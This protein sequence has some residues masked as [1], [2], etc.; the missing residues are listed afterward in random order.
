[1]EERFTGND[2]A[3][4]SAAALASRSVQR[5]TEAGSDGSLVDPAFQRAIVAAA[6]RA[7]SGDNC[8][9]WHFRFRRNAVE[10][11]L[12]LD[13]AASFFDYRNRGSFI[14]MGAV[15]EN[16][17]VQAARLGR[18]VE[19]SYP[20]AAQTPITKVIFRPSRGMD[21]R[22]EPRLRALHR[23]TVNRRPFLPIRIGADKKRQWHVEPVERTEVT[24]IERGRDIARWARV[25]YLGDRI[26]WTH[27]VIHRELFSSIRWTT[28]EAAAR[29]TGLELD[30]LGAGPFAGPIMRFLQPWPRMS[31]LARGGLDA[32]LAD[33]TRA[34]AFCAGA[35]VLVAIGNDRVEDWIRAGE[36]VQRLWLIAEQQELCVQPLPV[37][38]YLDQ[39]YQDEG[40]ANFEPRHR[41]LLEDVRG[42]LAGLLGERTGAMLYRVGHGWRMSHPAVR[43]PEERFYAS[44]SAMTDNG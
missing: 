8:Q 15:V 40:M 32:L 29:R 35:L 20:T 12:L 26:R 16:I 9:P 42:M 21:E 44:Q 31:R 41:A 39:R 4:H 10:I 6:I 22:W 33:Q 5:D 17:R 24:V 37:A 38:L 23:R 13:R 27:P 19:V 25:A 18:D 11:E 43:L 30:R 34:L 2:R 28:E 36:Q 3:P 7:P 1:M 14:S